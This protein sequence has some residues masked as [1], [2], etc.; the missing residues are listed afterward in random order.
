MSNTQIEIELRLNLGPDPLP[1]KNKFFADP[2]QA[3]LQDLR[4]YLIRC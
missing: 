3:P 4:R 2:R 1:A